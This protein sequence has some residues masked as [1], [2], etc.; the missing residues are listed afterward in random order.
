[1]NFSISSRKFLHL[2]LLFIYGYGLL[3]FNLR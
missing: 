1:M 2:L 3:K